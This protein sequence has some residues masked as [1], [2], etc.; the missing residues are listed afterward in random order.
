MPRSFK[1]FIVSERELDTLGYMS[2]WGTAASVFLGIFAGAALALGITLKTV[3]IPEG[4]LYLGFVAGF[5]VSV[6]LT[7]ILLIVVLITCYRMSKDAGRIKEESEQE[8]RKRDLL[9]ETLAAEK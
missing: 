1:N 7:V 8:Q 4:K 5:L 9:R 3:N 6:S 2:L